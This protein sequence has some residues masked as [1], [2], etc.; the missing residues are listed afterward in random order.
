MMQSKLAVAISMIALLLFAHTCQPAAALSECA[1]RALPS[2]TSIFL[3]VNIVLRYPQESRTND[4]TAS[5]KLLQKAPFLVD[6]K[7]PEFQPKEG[8]GAHG[9]GHWHLRHSAHYC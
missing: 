3:Y 4:L 7:K 2:C 8:L 1:P 6:K 9:D 5:R